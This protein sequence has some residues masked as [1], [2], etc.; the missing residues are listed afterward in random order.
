MDFKRLKM[1]LII[2]WCKTEVCF[3][4]TKYLGINANLL[5]IKTYLEYEKIRENSEE[6]LEE[7]F[8]GNQGLQNFFSNPIN[9]DKEVISESLHIHYKSIF[10]AFNEALNSLRL[11]NGLPAPLPWDE[12]QPLNLDNC[13]FSC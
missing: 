11:Y 9:V 7:E 3:V 2:Q 4:S 13:N 10:D 1:G 8:E 5:D 12:D 6:S